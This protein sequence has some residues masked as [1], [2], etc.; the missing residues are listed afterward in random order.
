MKLKILH[1]ED[2]PIDAELIHSILE[3]GGIQST[4]TLVES[5]KDFVREI[6]ENKFDIILADYS[7]PDFNGLTALKF[8]NERCPHTPFIFVSGVLGEELAIDSLKSGAKD[9]VLKKR[10]SRLGPTVHRALEE[11]REQLKRSKAE[12]RLRASLKE[13]E[14]LIKEIHHRV[15]NN[16]QI[17]SSLLNLQM[18]MIQEKKIIEIL[19]SSQNRVKSMALIHEILYDSKDFVRV[20]FSNYIRTLVSHLFFVY[21]SDSNAIE[22][23]IHTDAIALELNKAIPCGLIIS[24]LVSNSLKHAFQD[25][26]KISV[27]KKKLIIELSYN[28]KIHYVLVVG[29]NGSGIPENINL[30]DCDSLGLKLVFDL[31]EQ[32]E[33]KIE[34][35][36]SGGTKF[37]ISFPAKI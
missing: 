14:I 21:G 12:I 27:E 25:K 2:D 10:L 4:V 28:K 16:L 30:R 11:M 19:R 36:R 17:I 3:E 9:Y 34:L 35:D 1:L 23:H 6:A 24:E 18:N 7:L 5:E 8:A 26:K 32:L 31:T 29:D 13:K 20:D 22:L 15:K 33:G 37:I